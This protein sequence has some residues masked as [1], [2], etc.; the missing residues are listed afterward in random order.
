MGSSSG[1][2]S[3]ADLEELAQETIFSV[4]DLRR[5]HK[6]FTVAHHG[7]NIFKKD[8]TEKNIAFSKFGDE[9]FWANVFAIIDR[10][11][12]GVVTFREW[13]ITLSS[14]SHGD[15]NAKMKF[16]FYVMDLNGDGTI[17]RGELQKIIN[18]IYKHNKRLSLYDTGK[19]FEQMDTNL[20]ETI[21]L[22]EFTNYLST[23][24]T[25]AKS[26]DISK[27]IKSSIFQVGTTASGAPAPKVSLKAGKAVL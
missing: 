5:W 22:K 23:N 8:F 12:S 16:M 7:A 17:S 26:L 25:L 9:E 2:I 15:L 14:L 11:N 6:K 13:I 27:L 18:L 1:K 3:H 21:T 19:I 10:D 20:N 24:N 4:D